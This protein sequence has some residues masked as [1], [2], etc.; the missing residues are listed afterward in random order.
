MAAATRAVAKLAKSLAAWRERVDV[1]SSQESWR[2]RLQA[3]NHYDMNFIVIVFAA[4]SAIAV[5]RAVS[6]GLV[7]LPPGWARYGTTG[8]LLVICCAVAIFAQQIGMAES[9]HLVYAVALAALMG[10]IFSNRADRTVKVLFGCLLV[11]LLVAGSVSL[12]LWLGE[13]VAGV[14][15]LAW[16]FPHPR[17]AARVLAFPSVMALYLTI[18]LPVDLWRSYARTEDVKRRGLRSSMTLAAVSLGSLAIA[19]LLYDVQIK[20]QISR[21]VED[22]ARA[23]A[24]LAGPPPPAGENAAL[25]YE[26]LFQRYKP[27]LDADRGLPLLI[28]KPPGGGRQ[29]ANTA[30]AD[31]YAPALQALRAAAAADGPFYTTFDDAARRQ[32]FAEVVSRLA[33]LLI[34]RA[35][36]RA[37]RNQLPAA[38]D[39]LA[40]VRRVQ[41]HLAADLRLPAVPLLASLETRL[42]FALER[43]GRK[44]EEPDVSAWTRLLNQVPRDKQAQA[45]LDQL[46]VALS[47][48]AAARELVHVY[49]PGAASNSGVG[50]GT[51]H[52]LKR[53]VRAEIDL[54]DARAAGVPGRQ[55]DMESYHNLAIVNDVGI[56]S[57]A[58]YQQ[59]GQMPALVQLAAQ[60]DINAVRAVA[61]LV[62]LHGG[63]VVFLAADADHV[64]RIKAYEENDGRPPERS[65]MLWRMD[66]GAQRRMFF[67]GASYDRYRRAVAPDGDSSADE[68]ELLAPS[69][70]Q[71]F[72][73]MSAVQQGTYSGG[74]AGLRASLAADQQHRFHDSYRVLADVLDEICSLGPTAGGEGSWFHDSYGVRAAHESGHT[75]RLQFW[76]LDDLKQ[77]QRLLA[78]VRKDAFL[79][80]MEQLHWDYGIP[81]DEVFQTATW[82]SLTSLAD[83]IESAVDAQR[84]VICI[85]IDP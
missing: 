20:R 78:G 1:R 73:L 31:I 41:F 32:E 13:E 65:Q 36:H 49:L 67:V 8:L 38:V 74:L 50:Q 48:T 68:V 9:R 56:L 80:A 28:E 40:A 30:I 64:K 45:R 79:D 27:L 2:L 66:S 71:T 55:D 61:A 59:R 75:H 63:G 47:R 39:D 53:F 52:F 69:Q 42:L 57:A 23:E 62:P 58:S 21:F 72:A 34:R 37:A 46:N 11:P 51:S 76:S 77:R 83:F 19:V 18:V 35:E 85:T 54:R 82:N 17:L 33:M 7:A 6:R 29:L 81:F 22:T 26:D 24:E 15:W 12:A 16:S 3:S 25:A 10:F 43:V 70:E 4:L 14:N 5:A 84:P 60:L 44:W